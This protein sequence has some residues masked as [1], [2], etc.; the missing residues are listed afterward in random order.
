M[1]NN[2]LVISAITVFYRSTIY[3]DGFIQSGDVSGYLQVSFCSA[4]KEAGDN[5]SLAMI[6]FAYNRRVRI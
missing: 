6:S 2:S 3:T 4:V 1:C 5:N